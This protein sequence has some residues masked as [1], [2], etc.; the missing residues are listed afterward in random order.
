MEGLD[1]KNTDQK[2]LNQKDLNQKGLNQKGLNRNVLK[3]IAIFAMVIDHVGMMFV[4]I[5]T[6][7][8]VLCRVFG[9]L[10]A[11]IM[12]LFLSE[13]FAHTSSRKKYG[14]RLGIF[15]LVSQVPY[16]LAHYNTILKLDF[17]M[18][19]TLFLCFL[20][21]LV[22]E[23]MPD[24]NLRWVLI[25]GLIGASFICDWGIFAPLY[26]L[27]FYIYREDRKGQLKAFITISIGLVILNVAFCLG[28]GYHWYGE[29]WQLGVFLF[30][31]VLFLYNGERGSRAPFHKWIFYFFYPLHLLV[32]WLI[33]YIL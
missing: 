20:I 11:P 8:G 3:Y 6:F 16:A 29:L 25:G 2:D 5:S 19:F 12:C 9:R 32:L 21:L 7:P 30:I 17:N 10:T 23:Y 31:P 18:I 14:I 15:A 26:V 24:S 1:H 13:G 33:K 27:G 22:Y 28:Q 4:P